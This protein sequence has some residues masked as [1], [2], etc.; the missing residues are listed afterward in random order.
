ME[1]AAE[2]PDKIWR[3]GFRLRYLFLLPD[4]GKVLGIETKPHQTGDNG[5][6]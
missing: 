4:T 3:R 2:V 1:A 5:K 6:R